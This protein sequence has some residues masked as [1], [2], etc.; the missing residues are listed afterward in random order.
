[1]NIVVYT[2][3]YYEERILP[4]FIEHYRK[5]ATKFVFYDNESTDNSLKVIA[6]SGIDHEIRT[7]KSGNAQDDFIFLDIKNN[8]WKASRS[9]DV[10]YIIICDCDEFLFHEDMITFLEEKKKQGV[11]LFKPIGYDMVTEKFPDVGSIT[12]QIKTGVRSELL[13]KCAMFSPDA[14]SEINFGF[15]CHTANPTGNVSISQH[16]IKMLH[17]KNLSL[18]YLLEK[19][20]I[21]KGRVPEQ[22]AKAGIAKHYFY[23]DQQT[24]DSYTDK[25]K[26]ATV[27][28]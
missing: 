28:I 25:M 8:S 4:F 5:F 24:I 27:V 14:I 11:T 19:K 3:I 26:N 22:Y 18:E 15:G 6:D 9:K 12:E 16:E 13:D 7:Y 21:S 10:D 23:P 20:N 17:Y 1:M 2:M